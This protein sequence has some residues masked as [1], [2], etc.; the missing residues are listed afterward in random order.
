VSILISE[1][2]SN[3]SGIEILDVVLPTIIRLS[4]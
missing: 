2:F 1:Y 4:L 3:S